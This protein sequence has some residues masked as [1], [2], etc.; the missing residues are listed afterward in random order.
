MIGFNV[1][2]GGRGWS[3]Q[4]VRD[5]VADYMSMLKCQ[6][7]GEEFIKTEHN[8]MLREK[9]HGRSASAVEYKHQNISAIL[10]ELGYPYVIGYQPN[11][12]NYQ[13]LLKEVVTE[14][15]D[16]DK[17]LEQA[18]TKAARRTPAEQ[19]EVGILSDLQ[20]APPVRRPKR[21]RRRRSSHSKGRPG[22]D[23][24]A[25]ERANRALGKQGEKWVLS[26]ERKKL[27]DAGCVDLSDQIE[28]VSDKRGDGEG[29]DILSYD[30]YGNP[31]NIE[32]KTT[33]QGKHFPFFITA[34]EVAA[35]RELSAS[36]RVYRVF[37]FSS[38]PQYFVLKGAI[39]DNCNL[40]PLSF[41]ASL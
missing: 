16:S 19:P 17:E 10:T 30:K 4:E 41:E 28:W 5:T 12:V 21:Q 33:N 31:L 24:G 27:L 18:M 25:K 22:T 2:G 38:N 34:N 20:V 23:Y 37:A 8:K 3:R 36:F 15:V 39:E 13:R 6:L 32:V 35:S 40:R 1:A 26:L 9:L 14:Y 29:Y 7:R 11:Y